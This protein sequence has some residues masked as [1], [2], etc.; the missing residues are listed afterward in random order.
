MYAK[1]INQLKCQSLI[2][3]L[4]DV[5]IKHLNDS[6]LFIEYSQYIDDVEN[7][8]DYYNPSRKV[9]HLIVF[10]DVIAAVMNNK[11]IQ[12]NM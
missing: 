1:D 3:K 8:I 7:N 4:E 11:K 9:K 2:K 5:G 12:A 6:K 10:D